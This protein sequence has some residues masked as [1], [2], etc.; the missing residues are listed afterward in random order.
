MPLASVKSSVGGSWNA[1]GGPPSGGCSFCCTNASAHIA[2]TTSLRTRADVT[3]FPKSAAY[4]ASAEFD[5]CTHLRC[6]LLHSRAFR[7]RDALG[8]F[9]DFCQYLCRLELRAP[10][11]VLRARS[12][13]RRSGCADGR[14]VINM[15]Q[16]SSSKSS[17][18]NGTAIMLRSPSSGSLGVFT[19]E[20]AADLRL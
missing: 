1:F 4:R 5:F 20:L 17:H 16:S 7:F 18:D 11:P 13:P 15:F 10:L 6:D 3:A 19:G 14:M 2:N 12:G 8:R 9:A